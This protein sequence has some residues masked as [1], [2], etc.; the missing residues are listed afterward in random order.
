MLPLLFL[1]GVAFAV[2]VTRRGE[3]NAMLRQLMQQQM[4][5][6]ERIRSD[7]PSGVKQSRMNG[8]G[9][10][11]YHADSYTGKRLTALHDHANNALTVGLGEFVA[12]LNGV[13]FRT[14]HNDFSLVQPIKGIGYHKTETLT[15]P[16]VPDAVSNKPTIYEQVSEMHMWFKAWK[17][18][19]TTLRD[20]RPFFKPVLCYLE[21]AWHTNTKVMDES[22]ASDRHFLDASNWFDMQDKV[23]FTSYSGGKSHLENFSFLPTKIMNVWRNVSIIAQWNYRV[24]CHTLNDDL[25][26]NRLRVINDLTPLMANKGKREQHKNA[27]SARFQLNPANTDTWKDGRHKYGLLDELMAQI[28]GKDN[29]DA[30]LRDNAFGDTY[31]CNKKPGELVMLNAARY[32]RCY[33][34]ARRDAMGV[35]TLSRGFSDSNLFMAKTTQPRV[36]GM[37]AK[38]CKKNDPR[39][40]TVVKQKWSYAI[41]LEITYTNPLMTWNPYDIEYKVGAKSKE[42][43]LGGRNGGCTINDAYDGNRRTFFFRTPSLLFSG[44]EVN[45]DAADTSKGIVCVLDRAGEVRKVAPTG[46]RIILPEIFGVGAL[47]QRYPIMP[48]HVEGSAVWKE[49]DALKNYVMRR[50]AT[51]EPPQPGGAHRMTLLT[52]TSRSRSPHAHL[53]E[54]TAEEVEALTNGTRVTVDTDVAHQ[55]AHHITV[56]Y[57]N[58]IFKMI[59]CDEKKECRDKHDP[60]MSV[61]L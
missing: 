40:C 61:E 20:Y 52:G 25:P 36:A 48:V 41:P 32:H 15:F 3:A 7:G 58:A 28:P 51:K 22:F 4:F 1:V 47:R 2:G 56:R 9:T 57:R 55:H 43:T 10:R 54:I 13:E 34:I 5:V 29:Y 30:V 37:K 27:R 17:D 24:L 38:F 39:D 45:P 31:E 49:L 33:R 6:E 11:P 19:N 53:V 50:L 21:G 23:R 8:G 16:G 59:R 42:V 35:K 18:Q 60:F 46:L 12:V 44:K 26:L 14:R